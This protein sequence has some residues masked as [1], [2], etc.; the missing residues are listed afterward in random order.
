MANN[1]FP[2][3]PALKPFQDA[4]DA[5]SVELHRVFGN[6]AGDARFTDA[7]KGTEGSTLRQL[8]DAR[9]AARIAWYNSGK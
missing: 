8:Y 3:T 4:D 9:E 1:R 7:G 5:W 6:G 2:Y